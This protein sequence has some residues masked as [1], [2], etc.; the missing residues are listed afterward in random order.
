MQNKITR[1]LRKAR[2]GWLAGSLI[3]S[4]LSAAAAAAPAV[5]THPGVLLS[6]ADL[7]G[8]KADLDK[9]PWKAAYTSLKNDFRSQKTYVMQGPYAAVSR[10]PDVRRS[11]W[12]NDMQAVYNLTRMWYF[13]GDTGYAQRARDIL[14]AWATTQTSFGGAE[15][16]FDIGDSRIATAA[17]ILRATWPGWT[18]SDTSAVQNYFTTAFWPALAVPGPLFTG[19][20]GMEQMTGALG[21]AIFNDDATRFD[22]VLAAFLTDANTGLRGMLANGEVVDT[23]RDQGHTALY[24]RLAGEMGQAFWNQGVDVF[25]LRD[26]RI[27]GVGEYYA[28]YHLPSSAP[29]YLPFGGMSWGIFSAIAGAPRSTTQARTALN[30]LHTAYAVRKGLDTPWIDLYAN[31]QAEDLDSF[32][33]RRSGDTTSATVP[34]LP[35]LAPAATLTG[36]LT[37]ADLYGASPAGASAYAGGTWTLTGGY[38]GQTPASSTPS[39]RFAYRALTGD[40]TMIA[41]VVAVTSAGSNDAQGGIMIRNVATGQS[42]SQSYIAMTADH[43][44][45]WNERGATGMAYSWMAGAVNPAPQLPY[46]IKMERIGSRVQ[47]S[48]SPDGASWAGANANDFANM[49]ATAYVGLFASSA[50]TGQASSVT[51]SDVAITGGDGGGPTNAPPTPLSVVAGGADGRIT[52]RWSESAAATSYHVLRSSVSGGPYA[53]VAAVTG[54]SWTDTT[55]ANGTRYYYALRAS[56]LAGTSDVSVEDGAQAGTSWVNVAFG[57]SAS[58]SSSGDGAASLAFDSNPGSRWH[59]ATTSVPQWLQYDFGSAIAHTI[60]R[61]GVTSSVD[62]PSRDPSAWQL[63]ASQDGVNWVTL[64][65]QS[66]QAFAFK[67]QTRYYDIANSTAYRYYRLAISGGSNVQVAE[68][69]LYAST[70]HLLAN[71]SYRLL[72]RA[73]G[74]AA[75]VS[76]ASTAN[77][78]L[79]QLQAYAS[80]TASQQWNA[81]D[82]G[83]GRYQLL[84][85]AS[86]KAMDVT[87]NSTADGTSVELWNW[88][89]GNNQLWQL[90]PSGSGYFKLVSVN[91]GKLLDGAGGTLVQ[92]SDNGGAV[93]QWSIS[94]AP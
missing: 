38:N 40:F 73:T 20:Q 13:S 80:A 79:L 87:G 34:A 51:F 93:Q 55:A 90:V 1:T 37:A 19:S 32:M 42:Q 18:A 9:E 25:S 62:S 69:G 89:G 78:A 17:D 8:L 91:S 7:D 61:Y 14:L 12:L 74:Q 58:A 88:N 65:T 10:N 47:T 68:L 2:L 21:I 52:V 85:A 30:L 33:F 77:G 84:G 48:T 86:G 16:A 59:A 92:S 75:G 45:G 15:A 76:G 71:G 24:V 70:G 26:N 54:T 72:N 5:F 94:S 46:W 11:E 6:R 35:V 67:Y 39:I 44:A 28:R 50:V 82:M 53:E 31:D 36:A 56:N 22:Q 57:G 29:S 23:G 63:L 3:L 41:K 4:S 49:P 64:D 81:T 66:S 43:R 60:R 83:G 27:L